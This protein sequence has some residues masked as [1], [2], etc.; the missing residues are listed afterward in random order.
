MSK[1]STTLLFMYLLNFSWAQTTYTVTNSNDSGPGSLRQAILDAEVNPGADIIDLTGLTGTITLSTGLPNI[2]EDLTI[3]GAGSTST[4]IDGNNQIRPFFIGGAG[5][6]DTNAP[7]V[8]IND[9]TIQNGYAEGES[10]QQGNAGAGAGMGGAMFINNGDVTINNVVFSG[11]S[12]LGGTGG[13]DR[14]GGG[15]DGGDGPFENTGGIAAAFPPGR[16]E[17]GAGGYGAGGGGGVGNFN[18]GG[19]DGGRGGYGAGGGG[20]YGGN[21]GGLGSGGAAGAFGGNGGSATSI[22]GAGGGGGA[23]LGGALF[24]RNGAVIINNSSFTNN[25]ATGGAGG[26]VYKGKRWNSEGFW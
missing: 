19:A 4:I 3:N 7:V 6:N 10:P 9:L 12:V 20:A 22:A 17:G 16:F 21:L 2:T 26:N 23:G 24:I 11:N 1:F 25:T 8:N 5:V 13:N 18:F 15:G 14:F